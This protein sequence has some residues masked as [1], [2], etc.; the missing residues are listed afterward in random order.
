M[1]TKSKPREREGV[2]WQ[3]RGGSSHLDAAGGGMGFGPAPCGACLGWGCAVVKGM[4][5]EIDLL[6]VFQSP[7][8][9]SVAA[10]IGTAT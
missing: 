10:W 2:T 8:R 4:G 5:S 1:E 9:H 6:G 7:P 3:G